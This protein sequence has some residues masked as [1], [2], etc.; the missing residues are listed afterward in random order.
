M[1]FD[2]NEGGLLETAG[3][4]EEVG[5]TDVL[6]RAGTVASEPDVEA[7]VAHT[8]QRFGGLDTVVGVAGIELYGEGTRTCTSSS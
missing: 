3:L 1:P 8:V 6:T 2:R 7:A 4:F 5:Q